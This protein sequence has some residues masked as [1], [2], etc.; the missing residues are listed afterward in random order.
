MITAL[1]QVEESK[2]SRNLGRPRQFDADETLETALEYFW[3][4]GAR[5]TTR[6]LEKV[7]GISQSSIYNTF[8]SKTKLLEAAL[9]RYEQ[10]TNRALIEPLENNPDGLAAIDEF[11]ENLKTWASVGDRRGCM[12]INLMAEDGGETQA[13]VMRARGYRGRVRTA[14]CNALKRAEKSGQ[15]FAGHIDDRAE[16]LMCMVLGFNISARGGASYE[17]LDRL[18][19]SVKA[20]TGNWKVAATS[21]VVA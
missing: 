8:G 13:I 10:K 20:Q 19:G 15:T 14:L 5:A 3:K 11:F 12:L 6:Q 17:E 9:D 16:L 18:I 1:N 21:S 7:L 4:R 2:E